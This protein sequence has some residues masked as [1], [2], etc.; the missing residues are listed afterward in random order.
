MR[1]DIKDLPNH[2]GEDNCIENVSDDQLVDQIT[3]YSSVLDEEAGGSE[4]N[5]VA[6]LPPFRAELQVIA[7]CKRL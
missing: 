5:D 2:I 1:I 3:G 6:P 7:L 4:S